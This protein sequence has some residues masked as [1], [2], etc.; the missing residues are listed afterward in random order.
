[1]YLCRMII[2]HGGFAKRLVLSSLPGQTSLSKYRNGIA[3][4]YTLLSLMTGLKQCI[5]SQAGASATTA[6]ALADNE[7]DVA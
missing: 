2:E 5:A 7:V 4:E 1:M 3:R 6:V